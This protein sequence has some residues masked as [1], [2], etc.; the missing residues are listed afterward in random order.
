MSS[1]SSAMTSTT[2]GFTRSAGSDP[3]DRTT[4]RSPPRCSVN[5]AAICERPALWTQTYSTSGPVVAHAL[6]S[7]FD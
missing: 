6:A 7:V 3:A 2:I 4:T 5:S 1:P